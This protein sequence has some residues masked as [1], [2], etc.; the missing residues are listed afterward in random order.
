MCGHM[1]ID[2]DNREF[3][4]VCGCYWRNVTRI[5]VRTASGEVTPFFPICDEDKERLNKDGFVKITILSNQGQE[6]YKA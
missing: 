1:P 5:P 2:S 3:C 4:G 6:I